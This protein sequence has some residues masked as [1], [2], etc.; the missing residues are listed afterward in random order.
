MNPISDFDNSPTWTSLSDGMDMAI[1][2]PTILLDQY[3]LPV[4]NCL[5]LIEGIVNGTASIVSDGSFNKGQAVVNW[6]LI[7]V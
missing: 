7:L 3:Q 2:D 5:A 1:E 4:D 6:E